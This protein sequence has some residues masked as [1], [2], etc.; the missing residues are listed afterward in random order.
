MWKKVI[1]DNI[2]TNYSISSTGKLKNDTT[3][4]LLKENLHNG[5]SHYTISINKK[6]KKLRTHRLVATAFIPNPENK[7]YVNHIDG[8]RQNNNIENLE[9][10]TPSENTLHAVKIG[11]ITGNKK[12]VIQYSMDGKKMMVYPSIAEAAKQLQLSANKIVLCCQRKRRSHGDYQWRYAEDLQDVIRIEKK[13][14]GG[15][16]VACCDEDFNIICTYSSFTEAA[17][18]VNGCESAISRICSGTNQRHKGYRWK[19]V[20]DIVQDI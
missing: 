3:G 10:C 14:Y 4:R 18:A 9:W 1:V 8:N 16:K 5:Y 20:E 17:K 19:I 2:E 6:P 12:A 15:I 11:A 13:W 7:P